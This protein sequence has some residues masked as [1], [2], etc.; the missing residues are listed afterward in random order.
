MEI[1]QKYTTR[2]DEVEA[3]Q[4]TSENIDQIA[5]WCGGEVVREGK[6]SDPTD[7]YQ[8]VTVPRVNG[9]IDARLGYYVIKNSRGRFE[10]SSPEIF[11]KKFGRS[12]SATIQGVSVV[13]EGQG[14]GTISLDTDDHF[15]QAL[16]DRQTA[17]ETFFGKPSL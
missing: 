13:P 16:K 14:T 4:V 5:R 1:I 7:V 9:P 10:V 8:A 17:R 3:V 2:P 15:Q 11:E 6:A 12:V